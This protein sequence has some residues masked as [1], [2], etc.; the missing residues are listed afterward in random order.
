MKELTSA[1]IIIVVLSSA[2]FWFE[3]TGEDGFTSCFEPKAIQFCESKNLTYS[4]L[5][6][7]PFPKTDFVILGSDAVRGFI[8]KESPRDQGTKF[9]FLKEEKE[10]CE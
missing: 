4:Y 7:G 5:L 8:C 2:F 1:I 9:L 6:T 10:E 3:N